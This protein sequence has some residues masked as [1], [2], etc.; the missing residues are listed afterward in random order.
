[1]FCEDNAGRFHWIECETVASSPSPTRS[2]SANL[3]EAGFVQVALVFH[4]SFRTWPR[5]KNERQRGTVANGRRAGYDLSMQAQTATPGTVSIWLPTVSLAQRELVRFLR[6]RSRLIGA[7]VQPVLFWF[8]FGAGLQ[9]SFQ[10]PAGVG[11]Q[12]FFLPGVAV[13]IV[14][15]TAIFSTITVIEDRREGFL[16]GVL[17]SPAPRT[18]LVLGKLLGGTVLA[19]GQALLFLGLGRAL[20]MIGLYSLDQSAFTWAQVPA[21]IGFLTLVGFALTG[22]GYMIAWP[23][24]STHGFHAVMSVFLLP[25]WLLSGSF[26]PVQGSSWLSWV[27]RVNPLTYGVAGLRHL[28]CSPES[29]KVLPPWSICLGITVVFAIACVTGSVVL[30]NRRSSHNAR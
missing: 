11:Y 1:M 13:M 17:A 12:E 4:S 26:F 25:M 9:G 29:T 20:S 22:L 21:I 16:Q 27:M 6:Q 18:S 24:D 7:F 30:T 5:P 19:V 2:A 3:V 8:L 15:F 23:M 10:G 14:L 28:M